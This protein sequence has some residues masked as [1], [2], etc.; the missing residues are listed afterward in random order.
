M[1]SC[2]IG[3]E[4]DSYLKVNGYDMFI[5]IGLIINY[6]VFMIVCMVGNLGYRMYIV[7]DV[8]VC[9]DGMFY[10]GK[11]RFFVEDVYIFV[12]FFLYGEFVMVVFIKEIF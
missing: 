2:F 4:L 7:N 5:L 10:D 8:I 3:I 6:C 9:F 11:I 12:L 1:N